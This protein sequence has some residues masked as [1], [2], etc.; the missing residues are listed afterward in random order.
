MK[1]ESRGM[2]H[3]LSLCKYCLSEKANQNHR[4]EVLYITLAHRAFKFT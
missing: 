2:I 1:T 3:V 4:K